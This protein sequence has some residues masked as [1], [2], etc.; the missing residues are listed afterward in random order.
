MIAT[1]RCP[2][3]NQTKFIHLCEKT[4]GANMCT[5]KTLKIGR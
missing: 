1:I 2:H 4:T 5:M 3:I